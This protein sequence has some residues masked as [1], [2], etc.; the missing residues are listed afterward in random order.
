MDNITHSKYIQYT[1]LIKSVGKDRVYEKEI[2]GRIQSAGNTRHLYPPI[3]LYI[4]FLQL[5]DT[6]YSHQ[7][8][9]IK[10]VDVFGYVLY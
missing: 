4:L 6:V 8:H 5:L 1:L 10:N 9:L 7:L 3:T 2:W